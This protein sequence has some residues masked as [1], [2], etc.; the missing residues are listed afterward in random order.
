MN[1]IN[2]LLIVI[3]ICYIYGTVLKVG[4]QL[5]RLFRKFGHTKGYGGECFLLLIL[6]ALFLYNL[7][8]SVIQPILRLM[9][10]QNNICP[11]FFP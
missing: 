6:F 4:F 9:V 7:G 1:F 5:L 3:F 2:N 10:Y 11:E 8:L